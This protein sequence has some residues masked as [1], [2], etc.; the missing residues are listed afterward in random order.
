MNCPFCDSKP[1]SQMFGAAKGPWRC[2]SYGP[3]DAGEFTTGTACD[4]IVFRRGFIRCHDLLVKIVDGATAMNFR[5]DG[6]VIPEPLM[7]EIR[8][9][10]EEQE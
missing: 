6:W 5:G 2:G 10:V 1:T 3:D 8:K 4:L 7:S 9:E